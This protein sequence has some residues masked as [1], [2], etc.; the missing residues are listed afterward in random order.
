MVIIHLKQQNIRNVRDLQLAST[1]LHS[2][3]TYRCNHFLF[4]INLQKTSCEAQSPG[5]LQLQSEAISCWDQLVL[6]LHV[7]CERLLFVHMYRAWGG[8]EIFKH[9]SYRDTHKELI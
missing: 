3:K 8:P 1:Q 9:L 5:A 4:P 7:Q 2:L 6:G